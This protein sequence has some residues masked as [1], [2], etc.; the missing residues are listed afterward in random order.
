MDF[1]SIFSLLFSTAFQFFNQEKAFRKAWQYSKFRFLSLMNEKGE[2]I[3][4]QE[5]IKSL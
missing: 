2:G 3:P 4:F 5:K 1:L